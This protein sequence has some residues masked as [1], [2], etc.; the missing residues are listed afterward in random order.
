MWLNRISLAA[1]STIS[2]FG[3]VCFGAH[4]KKCDPLYY[5]FRS[6]KS[7]TKKRINKEKSYRCFCLQK[8]SSWS[9]DTHFFFFFEIGN[10]NVKKETMQANTNLYINSNIAVQ[11]SI[12]QRYRFWNIRNTQSWCGNRIRHFTHTKY[13]L[14]FYCC[15]TTISLS[16][17]VFHIYL[18]QHFW[19]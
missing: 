15:S 11:R 1:H 12:L 16:D 6:T 9:I 10:V 18:Y 5:S 17:S 4:V 2:T 14:I 7:K 19:F 8:S 13:L 3:I